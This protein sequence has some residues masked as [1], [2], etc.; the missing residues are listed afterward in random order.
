MEK[1]NSKLRLI[2]ILLVF[3]SLFFRFY[4]LNMPDLIE[5]EESHVRDAIAFYHNDPNIVP[6][7]HTFKHAKGNMGHPFFHHFLMF[8]SYKVLSPSN[9]SSRL[10]AV[11]MSIISALVVYHLGKSMFS[12]KAGLIGASFYLLSPLVFRVSRTAHIDNTF[13]AMGGL[14]LYYFY[15]YLKQRKIKQA[16]LVGLF[17]A[18]LFSSKIN[19]VVIFV[20]FAVSIFFFILLKSFRFSKKD[21]FAFILAGVVFLILFILFN[22]PYSY[23]DAI[24]NPADP[25]YGS[26]FTNPLSL[27]YP[28]LKGVLLYLFPLHFALLLLISVLFTFKK[29]LK[30]GKNRVEYIL[31]VVSFVFFF[32]GFRFGLERGLMIFLI[33]ACVITGKFI[34]DYIG[35]QKTSHLLFYIFFFIFYLPSL[36]FWGFRTKPLPIPPYDPINHY[37]TNRLKIFRYLN[38]LKG[39]KITVSTLPSTLFFPELNLRKGIELIP[40]AFR[41]PQTTDYFLTDSKEIYQN[42]LEDSNYELILFY[43]YNYDMTALFK[44]R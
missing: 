5:D 26:V 24:V 27:N 35:F 22:D 32:G 28:R 9:A 10:P 12:E 16:F 18:L 8:F 7:H 3:F 4:E 30:T 41:D 20:V 25:G 1:L 23:L 37:Y 42:K 2:L 29:L 19:G 38:N 14:S 44:R 43:E 13:A 6:R 21:I 17:S 15:L 36:F 39:E 40:V 31:L 11:L 34:T 33:P